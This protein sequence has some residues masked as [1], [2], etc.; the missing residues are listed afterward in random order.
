M[1][2]QIESPVAE[3]ED[4]EDEREE[5]PRDDVDPLRPRRELLGQPGGHSPP[6]LAEIVAESLGA[7]PEALPRRRLPRRRGDA[8][9]VRRRGDER[10]LQTLRQVSPWHGVV[11]VVLLSELADVV[12]VAC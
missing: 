12:V 2:Q 10:L 6:A 11:V 8:R 1:L 5:N 9:Q 7:P 3:V 4:G